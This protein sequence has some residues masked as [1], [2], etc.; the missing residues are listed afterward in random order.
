MSSGYWI[1]FW[2]LVPRM[3]AAMSVSACIEAQTTSWLRGSGG[4]IT[5]APVTHAWRC[6][7]SRPP[8]RVSMSLLDCTRVPAAVSTNARYQHGRTNC[9]GCAPHS[10][11]GSVTAS[12]GLFVASMPF[13]ANQ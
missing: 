10:A 7:P 9:A 2:T 1:R 13:T 3:Q 8:H 11:R 5:L 4:P 6:R 12:L